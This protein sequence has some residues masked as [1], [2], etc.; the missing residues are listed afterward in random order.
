MEM[1]VDM[2]EQQLTLYD[3]Y[4]DMYETDRAFFNSIRFF[5]VNQRSS[6]VAQYLR[7]TNLALSILRTYENLNARPPTR[8]V[9]NIPLNVNDISGNTTTN[10][11]DPVPV[12]PTAQQI[13]DGTETHVGV[14]D[15]T[16]SI[17]QEPVTCATRI[18]GCGHCFHGQCI[19]QWFS[20]NPRC[21][22]CRH[23]VRDA[24]TTGIQDTSGTRFAGTGGVGRTYTILQDASGNRTG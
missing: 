6:I 12:A 22:M 17:C 3:V 19:Q 8:M 1:E 9:L 15:T 13:R 10:F 5:D 16:C 23:D 7:N 11:F 20:M 14:I 21:P 4:H 18:R 24:V 2:E